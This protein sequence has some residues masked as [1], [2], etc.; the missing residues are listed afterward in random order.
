MGV[1]TQVTMRVVV[2]TPLMVTSSLASKPEPPPLLVTLTAILLWSNTLLTFLMHLLCST[3]L[4]VSSKYR[5]YILQR[6]EGSLSCLRLTQRVTPTSTT[7]L[8]RGYVNW[9][10]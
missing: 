4:G 5:I 8:Y 10:L 6:E 9:G 3:S 7:R 2:T 1:A